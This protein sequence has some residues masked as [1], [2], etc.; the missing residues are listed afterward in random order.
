MLMVGD[1]YRSKVIYIIV[2][3]SVLM[4]SICESEYETKG[5]CCDNE[6]SSGIWMPQC[7]KR[8]KP[9]VA[10]ICVG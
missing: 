5:V 4:A 8:T 6:T 2:N 7:L 3:T 9:T 10:C 1:N